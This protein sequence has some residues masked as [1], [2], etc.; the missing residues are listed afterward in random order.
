MKK[1]IARRGYVVPRKVLEGRDGQLSVHL[2]TVEMKT[3]L[4]SNISSMPE[5]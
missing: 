5:T 3:A 2:I 1:A 4:P